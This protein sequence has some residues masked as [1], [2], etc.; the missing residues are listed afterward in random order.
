MFGCLKN[1]IFNEPTEFTELCLFVAC[2][3]PHPFIL[4]HRSL[5][6]VNVCSKPSNFASQHF[7]AIWGWVKTLVPSEPQVIAGK[8]MFIPLKCIYSYWPIPILLLVQLVDQVLLAEGV[9]FSSRAKKS[10]SV[11]QP[12]SWKL[13]IAAGPK[14]CCTLYTTPTLD[15]NRGLLLR[16]RNTDPIGSK[17]WT[18]VKWT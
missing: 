12:L 1:G 6:G 14:R 13:G 3:K 17:D 2:L 15:T 5:S 18:R 8:W 7:G 10:I 16:D 9:I 11:V 4:N